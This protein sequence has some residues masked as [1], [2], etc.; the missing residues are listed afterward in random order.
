MGDAV[1]VGFA[2]VTLAG[3]ALVGFGVVRRARTPLTLGAALL[4]SAAGVWV[5][6]PA[7]ASVGLVAL[8][9]AWRGR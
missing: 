1:V 7:G 6:G 8:A 9:V 2:G 5:F 3:L 4:G